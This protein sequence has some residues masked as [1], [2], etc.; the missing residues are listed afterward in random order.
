M[1]DP[2]MILGLDE[3]AAKKE[4][5]LAVARALREG[6]HDAKTIAEAQ[7]TLFDPVARVRAGF[8]YRVDFGP[9]AVPV[10]QVPPSE[11][12]PLIER[13]VIS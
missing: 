4:I 5:M 9:Y 10:P 3:T 8:R 1:T 13:L 2:F 7:K 12:C 11:D 6:R